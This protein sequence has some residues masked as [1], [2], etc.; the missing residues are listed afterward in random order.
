VCVSMCLCVRVCVSVCVFV[1]ICVCAL[2]CL[3]VQHL[4]KLPCNFSVTLRGCVSMCVICLV[5][6]CMLECAA[7]IQPTVLHNLRCNVSVTVSVCECMLVLGVWSVRSV[8]SVCLITLWIVV[9]AKS[10]VFT[11]SMCTQSTVR[12]P[13]LIMVKSHIP[14]SS[15]KER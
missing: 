3:S 10:S 5:C 8:R 15:H 11:S 9:V 13:S 1:C 6:A 2:V 12:L 4:H 7:C 14:D